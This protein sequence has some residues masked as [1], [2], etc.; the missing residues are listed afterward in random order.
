MI[1][2]SSKETLISS[3]KYRPKKL[4]RLGQYLVRHLNQLKLTKSIEELNQK[5]AFEIVTHNASSENYVAL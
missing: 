1:V 4:S 3:R 2:Y 5:S